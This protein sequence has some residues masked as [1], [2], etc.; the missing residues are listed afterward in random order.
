MKGEGRVRRVR[1]K[2]I[3]G[4]G[5]MIIRRGISG[6]ERIRVRLIRIVGAISVG[7]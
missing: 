1:M 2:E 3:R 4:I 7:M 5:I 6:I